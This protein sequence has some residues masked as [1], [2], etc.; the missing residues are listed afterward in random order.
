MGS[1]GQSRNQHNRYSTRD[2]PPLPL[3]A[4]PFCAV[5]C[6][7]LRVVKTQN[8]KKDRPLFSRG[9]H[10]HLHHLTR[11]LTDQTEEINHHL[12][13]HLFFF[14]TFAPACS[15]LLGELRVQSRA[16]ER[17][18]KPQRDVPPSITS[19]HNTS[20]PFVKHLLLSPVILLSA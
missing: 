10:S 18:S 11:R 14:S 5:C 17:L 15:R 8:K 12:C 3:A 19:L 1:D 13:H 9:A 2:L 20:T 6:A 4:A 7:R 16:A